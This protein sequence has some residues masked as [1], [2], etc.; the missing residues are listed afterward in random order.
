LEGLV[1][2]FIPRIQE[3]LQDQSD[4][5]FMLGDSNFSVEALWVDRVQKHLVAV[6]DLGRG[7]DWVASI[8]FDRHPCIGVGEAKGLLRKL[9]LGG[10]SI[11][12]LNVTNEKTVGEY[13]GELEAKLLQDKEEWLQTIHFT[14]A[15]LLEGCLEK[16]IIKVSDGMLDA[17]R[18][19][20][21]H[22]KVHAKEPA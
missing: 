15:T 22:I 3:L 1:A 9:G 17:Q 6:Y 4:D 19:I 16:G 10:Y 18:K 2:K 7:S 14:I 8:L 21:Q 5:G 13:L 11:H 20:D 12:G